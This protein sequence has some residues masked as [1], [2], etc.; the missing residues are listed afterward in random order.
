MG[1]Y[2]D[3][4]KCVENKSINGVFLERFVKKD[5]ESEKAINDGTREEIDNCISVIRNIP[6]SGIILLMKKNSYYPIVKAA[7]VP[8][9]SCFDDAAYRVNEI[10]ECSEK[11]M[12][13]KELGYALM[14]PEKTGARVKYGENQA[15]LAREMGLVKIK[16]NRCNI[17]SNSALGDALLDYPIEVR[18][19]IIKRMLL[20]NPLISSMIMDVN[21]K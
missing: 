9:Y 2:S 8:Q 17:V 14:K 20:R 6:I 5:P 3:W 4:I 15:K 19:N 16:N 7:D 13:F 11:G 12:T 21:V 1:F 18:T 10:L